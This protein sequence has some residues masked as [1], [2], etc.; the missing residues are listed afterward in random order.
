MSHLFQP[1]LLTEKRIAGAGGP[2]DGKLSA[3]VFII[4]KYG[5]DEKRSEKSDEPVIFEGAKSLARRFWAVGARGLCFSFI[6]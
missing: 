3:S 6:M 4:K 1:P 2:G 5:M